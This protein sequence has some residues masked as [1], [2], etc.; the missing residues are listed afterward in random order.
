MDGEFDDGLAFW[1]TV[2]SIVMVAVLVGATLAVV[3]GLS[4]FIDNM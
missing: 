2:L 1:P 3:S 4:Y